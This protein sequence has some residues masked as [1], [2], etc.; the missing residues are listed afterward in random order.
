[1]VQARSSNLVHARSI[2]DQRGEAVSRKDAALPRRRPPQHIAQCAR[3]A[4]KSTHHRCGAVGG[5]GGGVRARQTRRILSSEEYSPETTFPDNFLSDRRKARHRVELEVGDGP[6]I[7][8]CLCA[9][10]RLRSCRHARRC[11]PRRR[12]GRRPCPSS[13]Q[14][15]HSNAVQPVMN[16][17]GARGIPNC[18]SLQPLGSSGLAW[19]N[20]LHNID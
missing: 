19:T 6:A 20:S 4:D 11:W 12:H 2:V 8:C 15:A 7:S 16:A 13:M 9:G 17:V 1:M 3:R 18:S 14:R 5:G 10:S